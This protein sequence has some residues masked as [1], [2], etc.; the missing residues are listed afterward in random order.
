MGF[1][2]FSLDGFIKKGY[3]EKYD[4]VVERDLFKDRVFE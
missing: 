4:V 2:K 1:L 3:V